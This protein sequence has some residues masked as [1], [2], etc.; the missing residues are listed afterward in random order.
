MYGNNASA[1]C[2]SNWD[3]CTVQVQEGGKETASLGQLHP[4]P[5]FASSILYADFETRFLLEFLSG[6]R[7]S[8]D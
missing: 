7:T 1:S 8:Q 3:D 5:G 6:L 4:F 2:K